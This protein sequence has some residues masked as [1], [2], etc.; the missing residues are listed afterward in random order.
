ME[1]KNAT[2][3]AHFGIVLAMVLAVVSEN[4]HFQNDFRSRENEKAAF[5]NSS[6]LDSVFRQ[7]LFR[8][9]FLQRSVDG[10][11]VTLFKNIS[12]K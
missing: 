1:F 11:E 12:T 4:L 10:G 9:K 6:G 8:D 5:S 3:S 2:I 7:F